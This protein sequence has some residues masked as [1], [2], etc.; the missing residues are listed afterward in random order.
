MHMLDGGKKF[1]V[2]VHVPAYL[3]SLT[4][5]A[6]LCP[7][8]AI[9]RRPDETLLNQSTDWNACLRCAGVIYGLH[10]SV[11]TSQYTAVS[12]PMGLIFLSWSEGPDAVRNYFNSSSELCDSARRS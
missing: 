8:I 10:A 9:D 6:A 5:Y 4:L 7:T 11:D 12:L 1:A 3:C 2:E